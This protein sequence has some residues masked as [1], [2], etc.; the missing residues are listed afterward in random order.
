MPG[1]APE[2]S[3]T[4]GYRYPVRGTEA[5]IF[6]ANQDFLSSFADSLE[7]KSPAEATLA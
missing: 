6:N 5:A 3:R 7:I 2:S 4:P 1:G